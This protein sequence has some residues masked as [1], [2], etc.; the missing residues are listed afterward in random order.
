MI[1]DRIK[2]FLN[3]RDENNVKGPRYLL[4]KYLFAYICYHYDNLNLK[5]SARNRLRSSQMFI[6]ATETMRK[7]AVI[8]FPW[9]QTACTPR[10]TGLPPHVM[11]LVANQKLKEKIEEQT[12]K[13]YGTFKVRV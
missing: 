9:N 7:F 10:F 12:T 4:M 5:L 13:N 6:G 8:K 3:I 2:T 11:M 1:E